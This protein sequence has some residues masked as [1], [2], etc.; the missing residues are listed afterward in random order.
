MD[1]NKTIQIGRLTKDSEMAYTTSGVCVTKFTIAVNRMKDKNGKENTDFFD[2]KLFGKQAEALSKYL[3]KGKQVCVE[4]ALQQERWERDG[5]KFSKVVII[6][7]MVQLLGGVK[8]EAKTD[9]AQGQGQSYN[10]EDNPF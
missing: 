2:V 8:A 7:D 1:I 4:G 9:W 10:G 6:A 5:Q 3:Q